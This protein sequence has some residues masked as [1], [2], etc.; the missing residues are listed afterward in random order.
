MEQKNTSPLDGYR[1]HEM[2]ISY[3]AEGIEERTGLYDE[4]EISETVT[5]DPSFLSNEATTVFEPSDDAEPNT[6]PE[7]SEEPASCSAQSAE[8]PQMKNERKKN[9]SLALL[10]AGVVL[11][12]GVSGYIGSTIANKQFI[13]QHPPQEAAPTLA[14]PTGTGGGSVADVVRHT[15]DSVVEITT[16]SVTRDP[17]WGQFVSS[18]AGSGVIVHKEGYIITNYHVIQKA[19]KITVRLRNGES[20]PA[21]LQGTDKRLDIAVI[22]IKADDLHPAVYGDSDQLTVGETAVA[23][24]NPLG[25]LG[26]TVTSGIISALN[27]DILI[28]GTSLNL[29]QTS[30]AVNRGNSGGGLFNARGELVGIV[31]AKSSGRMGSS[32]EGIGFAIPINDA[33]EAAEA[34]IKDGYVKGRIE[35]G[36]KITQI[37]N[38]E[39]ASQAGLGEPG[40][41]VIDIT[42]ENG[43]KPG[44]RIILLDG[45]SVHSTE[46]IIAAVKSRKDGDKLTFQVERGGNTFDLTVTLTENK[47]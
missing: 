3:T 31:N 7:L 46:E 41:Y 19:N 13:K 24:G 43:F 1:E 22:K 17:F 15:A 42:K 10:M 14:V 37:K 34:I 12:S 25:E 23:I 20:Y 16:E 2:D 39:E 4:P 29:L 40:I 11:L 28:E 35:I 30:A 44:D 5:T 33:K 8:M 27:R 45:K 26:G 47:E 21:T 36:I 32:I 38:K 18:G 6:E 9:P